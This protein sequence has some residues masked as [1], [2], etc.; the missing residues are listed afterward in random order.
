MYKVGFIGLGRIGYNLAGNI[1]K[2][3]NT[4]IWN[5]SKEKSIN[6]SKEFNKLITLSSIFF[7]SSFMLLET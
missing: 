2:K 7:K 3:C 6:H 1:S 5:R 4:Y